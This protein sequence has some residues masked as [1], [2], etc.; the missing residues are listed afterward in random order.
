[1]TWQLFSPDLP[2]LNQITVS[3]NLP[4]FWDNPLP[5]VPAI[6]AAISVLGVG[7]TACLANLARGVAIEQKK[8]A[9]DKFDIDLF[10]KRIEIYQSFLKMYNFLVSRNYS[11]QS[12]LEQ[13]HI[14]LLYALSCARFL[15][16]PN[17]IKKFKFY[18]IEIKKMY[19]IRKNEKNI[20]DFKRSKS[21]D[22]T[23]F[24]I[25]ATDFMNKYNVEL[26]AIIEKY[27][28]SVLSEQFSQI[29]ASTVFLASPD[30]PPPAA[31][32]ADQ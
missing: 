32:E 29:D 22:L 30:T 3:Q 23:K 1:M 12:E 25:I 8:I 20:D 7:V 21:K 14:D 26:R 19:N 5:Y 10:N 9:K 31:P 6:G 16:S 28:P 11:E 27:L 15:F 13:E 18:Q 2:F 4:S 17:D 24:N